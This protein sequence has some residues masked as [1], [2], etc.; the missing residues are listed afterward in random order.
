MVH[1]YKFNNHYNPKINYKYF[2]QKDNYKDQIVL[3]ICMFNENKECLI[4]T[5]KYIN[6][7]IKYLQIFRNINVKVLVVV[8]GYFF[9]HD[10]LIDFMKEIYNKEQWWDNRLLKPDIEEKQEEI[11][12]L[13][14]EDDA[15]IKIPINDVE[16]IKIDLT[17]IIKIDNR[18]KFNSHEWF[19]GKNGFVDNFNSTYAIFMDVYTLIPP[20]T[21]HLSLLYMDKNPNCV[22][23]TGRQLT[24]TSEIQEI[25]EKCL[26]FKNILRNIQYYN[27]EFSNI[28][29]S[30]LFS[31]LGLLHVIPGPYGFYRTKDIQQDKI[32]NYYFDFFKEQKN[33]LVNLIKGNTK[34]VEDRIL[35][36]SV[37]MNNNNPNS[38]TMLNPNV[39]FY[40]DPELTIKSLILQRRRWVNGTMFFYY[41]YLTN[42]IHF[43]NWNTGFIRKLLVYL[44]F[45]FLFTQSIISNFSTIIVCYLF[46]LS[47]E[48]LDN[49]LIKS[50][51]D[52]FHKDYLYL[53]LTI[54]FYINIIIH[55]KEKFNENY[56]KLLNGIGIIMSFF[57]HFLIA[58]LLFDDIN[59]LNKGDFNNLIIIFFIFTYYFPNFI[60]LLCGE[61][62]N[63]FR[64]LWS[65]IIY[66]LNINFFIMVVNTYSLGR[67]FDLSWGNRPDNDNSIQ[68]NIKLLKYK[69][70]VLL[71]IFLIINIL[72]YIA[73]NFVD[74]FM[75][76]LLSIN[77]ISTNFFQFFSGIYYIYHKYYNNYNI[78]D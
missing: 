32:R 48:C 50:K 10:S 73:H 28:T 2:Y 49:E 38:Y 68:N 60:L 16:Y 43:R 18:K 42:I 40:V 26:S 14:L 74:Y 3:L 64:L 23:S 33:E 4:Q 51:N 44:S 46:K 71:L 66:Y 8:D 67:L 22:A 31:L 13:I 57:I 20:P 69:N 47:L 12:T 54:L 34:I 30:G 1:Y 21:I 24:M 75:L 45:L 55:F 41:Y 53:S 36:L 70:I 37:V 72:I 27:F 63:F 5:L 58:Y 29:Y 62:R 77:I 56:I 76:I 39:C 6:K 9:A 17:T 19:L 65:S 11:N 15:K 25:K 61:F 35:S 52:F 78:N 59:R 7:N